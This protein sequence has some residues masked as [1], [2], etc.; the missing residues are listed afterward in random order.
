MN[1]GEDNTGNFGLTNSSI[2]WG[3]AGVIA[4]AIIGLLLLRMLF[5]NFRL[6][7]GVK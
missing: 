7:G 2:V 5:A 6:E 3:Y 4:V 1:L